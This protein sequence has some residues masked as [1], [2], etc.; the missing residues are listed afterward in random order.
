[1][2]FVFIIFSFFFFNKGYALMDDVSYVVPSNKALQKGLE[3]EES[4]LKNHLKTFKKTRRSKERASGRQRIESAWL[5]ER[6]PHHSYISFA[7]ATVAFLM[8]L[9]ISS[10]DL[11]ERAWACLEKETD[12]LM[13]LRRE[14]VEP[15]GALG[16]VLGNPE[17]RDAFRQEQNTLAQKLLAEGITEQK[18]LEKFVALEGETIAYDRWEWAQIHKKK[19][20][21][22]QEMEKLGCLSLMKEI[23]THKN[24][25]L[26]DE[27]GKIIKYKMT[28]YRDA[29]VGFYAKNIEDFLNSE[30]GVNDLWTNLKDRKERIKAVQD[31]GVL[32]KC[33]T[34]EKANFHEKRTNFFALVEQIR[35]GEG[36][37]PGK[38][39]DTLKWL[40]DP[41][42][43]L[44]L[45]E[46]LKALEEERTAQIQNLLKLEA[47]LEEKIPE[48]SEKLKEL[49]EDIKRADAQMDDAYVA[50]IYSWEQY[51]KRSLEE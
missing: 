16:L 36:A 34:N 18:F 37:M 44:T 9:D 24:Q 21:L 14:F 39:S 43:V 15:F 2:W 19:T 26:A 30:N 50:A 45:E 25:L 10:P 51:K 31:G 35:T 28:F 20:E 3:D 8:A 41:G 47:A 33:L 40:G 38:S 48:L 32:Y 22:N 4:F 49:E 23:Q 13:V 5:K 6:F 1:M 42:Q 17:K 46:A 7:G 29:F 11:S 27:W 12:K